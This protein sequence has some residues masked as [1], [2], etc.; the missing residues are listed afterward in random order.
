MT[1]AE[2]IEIAIIVSASIVSLALPLH[3]LS[4]LT[5]GEIV[6]YLS[7]LLL[8]QGLTRDLAMLLLHRSAAQGGV[9]RESQCLCLESVV[10]VTGVVAGT[11]LF[12]SASA[13]P[14]SVTTTSGVAG[15]VAL[16]LAAGFLIKDLVIT[17]NPFGIRR[18][19]NPL[20]V[21]IRSRR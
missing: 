13:Y 5:L 21:I 11:L 12:V 19:K 18:E 2:W 16:T 15:A 9:F 8:A 3:L 20:S 7:A 1:R 10:G 14:I 17:W 4:D 6:L